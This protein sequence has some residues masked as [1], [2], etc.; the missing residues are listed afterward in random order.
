MASLPIR[1][2]PFLEDVPIKCFG[3]AANKAIELHGRLDRRRRERALRDL[4]QGGESAAVNIGIGRGWSVREFVDIARKV[5]GRDIPM[6]VGPRRPGDPPGA[7]ER[8]GARPGAAGVVAAL[9]RYRGA[10]GA[11]LELAPG[12]SRR[13]RAGA[14]GNL[15][16]IPPPVSP[17]PRT[18]PMRRKGVF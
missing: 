1:F 5:T 12:R 18:D 11:C 13:V 9:C 10:D 2:R 15:R 6:R 8:P 16:V 7:R 3:S 4:L 14:G 17:Q